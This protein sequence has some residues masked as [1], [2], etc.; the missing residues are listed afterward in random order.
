MTVLE[1]I[2]MWMMVIFV[3]TAVILILQGDGK[4]QMSV[5]YMIDGKPHR[6]CDCDQFSQTCPRGRKRDM[7]TAG[8]NR[9]VVPAP[10]A[11]VSAQEPSRSTGDRDDR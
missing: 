11:V 9:C 2:A 4:A 8:F 1:L 3:P 6:E 5:I 10:D 7:M